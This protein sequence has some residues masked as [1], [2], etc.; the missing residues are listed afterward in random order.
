V[1]FLPQNW[2]E[3]TNHRSIFM[4]CLDR[5]NLNNGCESK[6]KITILYDNEA[7]D[8]RPVSDRGF[9]F[10]IKTNGRKMLFDAGANG[11]ILLDNM[12]KLHIEPR[13]ADEIFISHA[14]WDHTGGLSDFLKI[15]PVRIYIPS[16]CPKPKGAKEQKQVAK[17]KGHLKIHK[18]Y[19]LP[20]NSQMWNSLLLFNRKRV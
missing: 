15:H 8:D 10:L 16:S 12:H 19:I 17:I 7:V 6:M 9:S 14:H 11:C 2:F 20:V 1:V 18:T 4:P 5:P 3:P 13:E